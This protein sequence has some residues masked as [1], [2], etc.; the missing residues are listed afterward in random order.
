[1][2]EKFSVED[3]SLLVSVARESI[4]MQLKE[5]K[6]D[7]SIVE[8]KLDDPKFEYKMGIFVTLYNTKLELRG[9]VGFPRSVESVKDGVIDSALSAAF[10]DYRFMK[11]KSN[12]LD[13]I[14]IEVS[15]LSPLKLIEVSKDNLNDEIKIGEDGLMVECGLYSGLLLPIVGVEE[16]FSPEEFL[17]ETCV[18]AGLDD[19]C[20]LEKDCKVYKFQSQVFREMA[21]NGKVKEIDL[22]SIK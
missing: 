20:W 8:K 9:C 5:S 11:L 10:E 4:L 6:V 12:E 17:N 21:P 15:L 3:A 18:K 2:M 22:K 1:M 14:I 19:N 7:K 13:N 16:H